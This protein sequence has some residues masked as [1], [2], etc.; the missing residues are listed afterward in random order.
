MVT[1]SRGYVG[2]HLGKVL[3]DHGHDVFGL[4]RPEARTNEK[5]SRYLNEEYRLSLR[6]EITSDLR[7]KHFDVVVHTAALVAAGESVGK[8]LAYTLTNVLG[9]SNALDLDSHHFIHISTVTA[10]HPENPYALSKRLSEYVVGSREH[11]KT[12]ILRL[13]NVAGTLPKSAEFA[14]GG[15]ATH[16]IRVA[17]AAAAKLVS[18][19]AI[20]GTDYPTRD[21]TCERN[22]VHVLDVCESIANAIYQKADGYHNICSRGGT[23]TCREVINKMKE[24]SGVDFT[25]VEGPRREGDPATVETGKISDLVPQE[26]LGLDIMCKSAYESAVMRGTV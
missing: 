2:S 22:Y 20:N 25:V 5:V 17:A 14:Q 16:L 8:P 1:G 26:T 19:I 7:S 12:T 24:V 23:N 6:G 4:D 11:H 9:T 21:G 13:S 3:A 18:S 15:P 10:E